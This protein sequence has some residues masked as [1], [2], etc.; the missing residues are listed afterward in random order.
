MRKLRVSKIL[1]PAFLLAL[2]MVGCGDADKVRGVPLG[3]PSLP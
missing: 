2:G 3:V 1:I